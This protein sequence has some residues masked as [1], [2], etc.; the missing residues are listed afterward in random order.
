MLGKLEGEEFWTEN[1]Y[2]DVPFHA[3]AADFYEEEG[4][5]R[6]EFER[7]EEQ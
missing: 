6:D 1:M 7:A 5:W 3:A 2:D 4:L